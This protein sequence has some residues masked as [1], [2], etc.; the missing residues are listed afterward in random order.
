MKTNKNR[1]QLRLDQR[2]CHTAAVRAGKFPNNI[3]A[4]SMKTKLVSNDI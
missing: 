4:N 1:R 3:R 2:S